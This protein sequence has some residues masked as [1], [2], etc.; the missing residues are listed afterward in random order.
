MY[1]VLILNITLENTTGPKA[2]KTYRESTENIPEPLEWY[3]A[4]G[5]YI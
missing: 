1:A 4:L 3:A 2:Q 5:A